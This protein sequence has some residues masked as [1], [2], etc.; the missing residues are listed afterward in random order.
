M[1]IVQAVPT[2]GRVPTLEDLVQEA[3]NTAIGTAEILK[4]DAA[5]K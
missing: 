2:G 5:K 4:I 3:H 1:A